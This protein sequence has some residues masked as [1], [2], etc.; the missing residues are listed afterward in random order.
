MSPHLNHSQS[1][2][3]V[4]SE[5]KED[6]TLMLMVVSGLYQ[7]P[8]KGEDDEERPAAHVLGKNEEGKSSLHCVILSS[9]WK[10]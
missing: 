8:P 9:A 10:K 2:A 3:N 5:G 7:P 1:L 6:V 4:P